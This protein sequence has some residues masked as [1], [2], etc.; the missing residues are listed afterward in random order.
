MNKMLILCLLLS[1]SVFA[2]TQ[3]YD[4]G[5]E[6]DKPDGWEWVLVPDGY[7][8]APCDDFYNPTGIECWPA[9]EPELPFCE[10]FPDDPKCNRQWCVIFPHLCYPQYPPEKY[11]RQADV[12]K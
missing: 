4:D 3:C 9:V 2:D 6:L 12:F 1:G 8:T 11:N 10:E 7:N 5:V